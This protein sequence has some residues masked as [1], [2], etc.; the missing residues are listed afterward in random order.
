M[1]SHPETLHLR[2]VTSHYLAL[3]LGLT[4]LTA[5]IV[6]WQLHWAISAKVLL[7]LCLLAYLLWQIRHYLLLHSGNAIIEAVMESDELW[8]LTLQSGAQK[9]L[10]LLP[11][12]FVRPWLMIL[13]FSSGT[14]F[15]SL[16]LIL[17]PDSLDRELAR[18][19]RVRL[20]QGSPVPDGKQFDG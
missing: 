16:H 15:S 1:N 11:Y 14:I 10:E 7:S 19:L 13:N 8:R 6:L 12:S 3:W 18:K 5:M 20:R 2:P 9:Q 4:H 17:F